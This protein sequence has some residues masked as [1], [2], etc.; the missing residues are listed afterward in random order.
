MPHSTNVNG[1]GLG[2]TKRKHGH[3][4]HKSNAVMDLYSKHSRT[5]KC[6]SSLQASK[7]NHKQQETEEKQFKTESVK[8]VE[9]IPG[10]RK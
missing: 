10:L 8:Q 6:V 7:G 9:I 2:G 5:E 3:D 1:R 4:L